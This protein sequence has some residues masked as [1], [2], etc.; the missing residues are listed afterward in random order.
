MNFNNKDV[1]AISIDTIAQTS[2]AYELC[3]YND[4]GLLEY[5]YN[6]KDWITT[7]LIRTREI[8]YKYN[9][10]VY[11]VKKRRELVVKLLKFNLTVNK[12]SDVLNVSVSTIHS[13]ISVIENRSVK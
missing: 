5:T 11:N 8:V 9:P 12:M 4:I 10:K 13:D 6:G 3:W 7:H 2:L 1:E